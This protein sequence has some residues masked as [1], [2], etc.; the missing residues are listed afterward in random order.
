MIQLGITGGIGSGKS[1]VAKVLEAL[2]IP[3]YYADDESKLLLASDAIQKKIITEFGKNILGA[4]GKI[5]RKKLA[6]LVFA[7]PSKLKKLNALLHPEVAK[8]YSSWL[9]TK[10]QF[11]IVAKEAAILFESGSYTQMD[12]IA[13]V[14]APREMRIKRAMQRSNASREEILERIKKQL[15]E[16]EKIRRADFVLYNDEK[17]L[18]VPQVLKMLAKIKSAKK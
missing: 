12:K 15:P 16:S 1:T 4:D 3:V 9:K 6:A 18:V 7:H 13:T 17:R 5:E 14:Y 10:K 8:H 2:G 11:A